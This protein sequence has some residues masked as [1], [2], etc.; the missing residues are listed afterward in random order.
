MEGI[1]PHVPVHGGITYFVKD[2]L[3]ADYGFDTAH[4]NS[5]LIPRNDTDFMR[6]Q[7]RVLYEGVLLAAKLERAYQRAQTNQRRL[8]IIAPLLEL[9]PEQEPNFGQM[10]RALS[11]EI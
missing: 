1:I 11:G 6:W 7:C 8:Q 2:D 9:V 10:V 5:E 3:G 4:Y